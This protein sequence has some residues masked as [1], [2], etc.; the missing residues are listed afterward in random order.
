MQ[1]L[2]S[3]DTLSPS[4]SRMSKLRKSGKMY[5][6]GICVLNLCIHTN[7]NTDDDV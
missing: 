4:V 7:L 1:Q 5:V 6:H 2:L 3:Q